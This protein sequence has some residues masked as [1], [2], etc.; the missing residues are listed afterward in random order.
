MN[1][2]NN[3]GEQQ[4]KRKEVKFQEL[5]EK[6]YPLMNPQDG[7]DEYNSLVLLQREAYIAGL[8]KSVNGKLIEALK[9]IERLKG[10][11]LDIMKVA[12]RNTEPTL[13]DLDDRLNKI[14]TISIQK[15]N[16]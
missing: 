13:V 5:A 12:G 9:E 4:K 8:S 11:L 3:S 16:L 6:K 10:L 14:M 7:S 15:N 2:S 1:T